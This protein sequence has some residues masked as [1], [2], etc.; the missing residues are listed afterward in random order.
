MIVK[1]HNR[2]EAAAVLAAVE[3]YKVVNR[4]LG[5]GEVQTKLLDRIHGEILRQV[6]EQ[7]E[8]RKNRQL[9]L[10]FTWPS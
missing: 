1:L 9:Q 10:S 5:S 4:Q 6:K 3:L 8:E 7:D 2:N